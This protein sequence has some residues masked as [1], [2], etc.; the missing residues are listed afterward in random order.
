MTNEVSNMDNLE[1]KDHLHQVAKATKMVV[2]ALRK[3]GEPT[4]SLAELRAALEK[5]LPGVSLSDLITK[6]RQAGW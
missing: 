5:E 6:E 1:S 2:E 4:M 3:Y